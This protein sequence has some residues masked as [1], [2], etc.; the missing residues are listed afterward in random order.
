MMEKRKTKLIIVLGTNG[1]GKTTILEKFVKAE[2][3][4]TLVVT[5]DDK[6]WLHLPHIFDIN[7]EN[8]T[9]K[10]IKRRIWQDSNDLAQISGKFS[11]GLLVFDD[12]RSYF[13]SAHLDAELHSL[14]IRRRQKQ[15]D[16]IVA[17]HGFSEVPPKF[18]TFATEIVLFK[19]LD[20]VAS[21][22]YVVQDFEKMKHSQDF[23]NMRAVADP[24]YYTIIKL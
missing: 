20:N 9:Y 19:T 8:F 7:A 22:K 11:N 2:K 14:L 12:C 6:D 13:S 17:A 5:P 16:I 23:V 4:K 15:V 10:S 24:H 18:Y 21:R 1:T 3:H